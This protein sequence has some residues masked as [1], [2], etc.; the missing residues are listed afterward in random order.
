[1]KAW[2]LPLFLAACVACALAHAARAQAAAVT[3]DDARS[4]APLLVATVA[5]ASA[6]DAVADAGERIHRFVAAEVARA[7]PG[8]RAEITVGDID[9]R[10]HLAPCT[11]TEAFL[12]PGARLWG[13]SFVGYRCTQKPG[14]SISVPVMV[15]LFGTALVASQT[16]PALQPISASAL[17]REEVEMTREPG[18]VVE[19]AAQIEDQLCTRGVEPGQPIPLNALRAV[20]AVGQGETVKL[21][22]TG[23]GF[24]ISTDA[25]ALATA[26]PG[27]S[28]RV[29]VESGRTLSGVARKG[30]IVEVGF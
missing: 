30:R 14:W 12:R 6:G 10:L 19:D 3:A 20:P 15:R 26:A 29:R 13:R 25:I 22:G 8:L 16:L 23:S 11:H 24:S 18:G 7:Q 28:V 21:V 17:R 4:G 9:S 5:P 27:E 1:M 2:N